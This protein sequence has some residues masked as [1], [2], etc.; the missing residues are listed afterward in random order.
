MNWQLQEAKNKLSKVIELAVKK[1]PQVITKR[2][3]KEVVVISFD[4]Y[5]RV[6]KKKDNIIEFFKKSPLTKD[7][8][9]EREKDFNYRE[10]N[11]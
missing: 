8:F 3:K 4:E 7:V 11:L 5:E 2:G 1:G 9:I 10:I 6:K